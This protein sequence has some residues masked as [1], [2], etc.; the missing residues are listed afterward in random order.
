MRIVTLFLAISAL[1]LSQS[2]KAQCE[3]VNATFVLQTG[4]WA[5]EID[6]DIVNDSGV[7]IY[8]LENLTS[9]PQNYTTYTGEL[10]LPVGCYTLNQYDGF[11]DGWNGGSITLSYDSTM[12]SLPGLAD[13]EFGSLGFGIYTEDCAGEP[14]GNQVPGCTDPSAIN[15]QPWATVDNGSCQYSQECEEGVLVS[16]YICTFSN[17]NQVQLEL[18]GENGDLLFEASNLGNAAIEYFELC[19]PPGECLNALMSNTTGPNGW[20]NGYFWVNYNGNQVVTGSLQPGQQFGEVAFSLSGTACPYGGCTDQDALNFDAGASFDDGSCAYPIDCTGLNTVTATLWSAS[21]QNQILWYLTDETSEMVASGANNFGAAFAM[22]TLCLADGCYTLYLQSSGGPNAPGGSLI[23]ETNGFSGVYQLLP[24][25]N[26]GG[27]LGENSMAY[28]VS[29]NSECEEL[30]YGCTDAAATNYDPEAQFNDGSC[31]YPAPD[32]DLCANATALVPG[33]QLISN[34]NAYQNENIWGECWAF[35]SGEG[36]QTS[37]WFTF[38]TPGDSASIHIEAIADGTNTLTDTQFGL[39][40]ECG[41]EMIYCDGNS[42]QG[43]LSAFTFGCG[44][45]APNTTYILMVDGY[46]GDMG[47]CYLNYEVNECIPVMGCTDASALNYNPEATQDDG[48]CEYPGPCTA[49]E[50]TMIISTQAWGYE[51]S[52]ALVAADGTVVAEGDAYNNYA[53]SSELLCIEDGCYTIELYDSFGDGWN[54]GSFILQSANG[55]NYAS[56]TLAG[57]DFTSIPVA[58]NSE[59]EGAEIAGCTDPVAWNFDPN[60]TINDGSCQ[61]NGECE[62]N[63]VVAFFQGAMWVNEI[64]WDVVNTSG[65]IVLAGY[66]YSNENDSTQSMIVA[67]LPNGCYTV[68][69]YDSFGDG[70]NGASL[71]LI[72]NGNELVVGL[73]SGTS[74]SVGFGINATG[75]ADGDDATGCTD[76]SALNYNPSA[77]E[78]DGSC[79]YSQNGPSVNGIFD[80]MEVDLYPNPAEGNVNLDIFNGNG[81]EAMSVHVFDLQGRVVFT[82]EFGLDQERLRVTFD[83]NQFPAGVYL[84]QVLN[85]QERHIE[86]LVR[87]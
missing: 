52:W 74:G 27:G 58:I 75:C 10:C 28:V 23:L 30:A 35:G 22:D 47:T 32:N 42:G 67:C 61:Y 55:G 38:T 33:M 20:Y 76:P 8:S 66:G 71:T 46:F 29:I 39:F 13:G 69:M 63:L 36:E 12:V 11:G 54:G 57:G 51:V 81:D 41:G 9:N 77:T 31:T 60:A 49:N 3:G 40:T 19:L 16:L 73:P 14:I 80:P 83:A 43:L 2:A 59:C 44:E 62:D 1:F 48:S 7:V 86:R 37:V 64:S 4:Q 68:N 84:V 21:P 17:G 72:F 45:L 5:F 87:Q 50:V 26:I 18:F 70:W 24:G 25:D 85:G 78:D 79:L 56:G 82:R 6:F 53:V 34:V 65:E 15:Y